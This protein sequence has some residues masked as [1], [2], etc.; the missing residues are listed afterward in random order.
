MLAIS[1]DPPA[2]NRKAAEAWHIEFPL[3]SDPDARVIEL[4]GLRHAAGGP[5][6]DIARPATWIVDRQ[7]RIVW[8]DLTDNWRVRTRPE[9]VLRELRRIP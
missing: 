2:R 4:Y 3:L 1:V 5:M 8:R 9:D 7:G 6:G